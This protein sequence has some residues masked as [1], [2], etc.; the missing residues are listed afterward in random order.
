MSSDAG[1]FGFG[2]RSDYVKFMLRRGLTVSEVAEALGTSI[3]NLVTSCPDV[4][5]YAYRFFGQGDGA[6]KRGWTAKEIRPILEHYGKY[7]PNWEGWRIFLPNKTR[8]QVREMASR[9][10]VCHRV[11]GGRDV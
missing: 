6:G 8:K 10:G 7:G 9:L 3:Y 4:D 1:F 5:F 2:S 11:R